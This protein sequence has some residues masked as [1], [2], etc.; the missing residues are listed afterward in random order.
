MKKIN[1]PDRTL[2]QGLSAVTK[3]TGYSLS[4]IRRWA[5]HHAFPIGKLP[6]GSWITSTEL[7]DRWIL[8]RRMYLNRPRGGN[9]PARYESENESEN[10]EMTPNTERQ[11]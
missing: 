11:Y 8:A 10:E 1:D 3:Y 4:T 6:D 9:A 5:K 7:I 2:I